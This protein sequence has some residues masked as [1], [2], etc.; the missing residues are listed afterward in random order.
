MFVPHSLKV[1]VKDNAVMLCQESSPSFERLEIHSSFTGPKM[2]TISVFPPV[3][4]YNVSVYHCIIFHFGTFK[5]CLQDQARR[6][7]GKTSK[8]TTGP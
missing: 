4:T 7:A 8:F 6:F 2:G 5:L 1:G 3:L